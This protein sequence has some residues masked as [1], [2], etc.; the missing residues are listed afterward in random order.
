MASLANEKQLT[1][2]SKRCV[3]MFCRSPLEIIG[4]KSGQV[5]S[6]NFGVNELK[7]S[8]DDVKAVLTDE[9]EIINC[10]LFLRS[11][12]YRAISI[13]E[14]IP[15]DEKTGVIS[16]TNG[17]VTGFD[18]GLYCSGWAA[19]GATGVILGT[20]SSSF[21]IGEHILNDLKSNESK[22]T[23]KPGA[24]EIIPQLKSNGVKVVTF[25][26]WQ[27]IDELEKSLGSNLG[28]PREKLINQ[29]EMI[30]AIVDDKK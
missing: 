18:F 27:R 5:S 25:S 17:K 30:K 13:D 19:T 3:L 28:K 15:L 7:P 14:S 8:G 20:M 6:V 2:N 26:D 11:I 10:G 12:G 22:L 9:R 29:Q 16:N 24:N 21:E 4:N 1:N 23:E